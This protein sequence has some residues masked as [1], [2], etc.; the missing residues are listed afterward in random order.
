MNATTMAMQGMVVSTTLA[1]DTGGRTFI[2]LLRALHQRAYVVS[3]ASPHGS[4]PH[5]SGAGS[6]A[7]E[8]TRGG[9]I[10]KGHRDRQD[11]VGRPR[12][13]ARGRKMEASAQRRS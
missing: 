6:M 11:E 9:G 1:T 7:T 12:R 2:G 4:S 5:R 8:G 3:W 10:C 13:A